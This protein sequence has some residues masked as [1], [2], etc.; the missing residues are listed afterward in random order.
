MRRPVFSQIG[1]RLMMKTEA[2][3]AR[4]TLNSMNMME[5]PW[6]LREPVL[7]YQ[8]MAP[9][10]MIRRASSWLHQNSMIWNILFLTMIFLTLIW[11]EMQRDSLITG[12]CWEMAVPIMKEPWSNGM[13]SADLEKKLELSV[14]AQD[15]ACFLLMEHIM[16]LFSFRRSIVDIM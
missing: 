11:Q 7:P 12:W 3:S 9:G 14:R 4:H 6:L 8:D 10:D 5:H 2:G 13:W 1:I 15:Q 16:V